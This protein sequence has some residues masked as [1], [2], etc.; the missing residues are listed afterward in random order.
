MAFPPL[1]DMSP[2]GEDRYTGDGSPPPAD[3]R[4]GAAGAPGLSS[5]DPDLLASELSE[6]FRDRIR[7][8]AA[9]RLRDRDAAEDVAQEV[10]RRTLEALRAG[11]V[12]NRDALPAFLFQTARHVCMQWGRSAGRR[13][14]AFSRIQ[15]EAS[16]TDPGEDTLTGLITQERREKVREAFTHLAAG[17]REVLNLSYVEALGADEIAR[18]LSSTPGAVRVRRHRA[19]HRLAEILGVTDRPDREL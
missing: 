16:E 18:R 8:F 4:G 7:F 19:L 10:L 17:D 14:R 11:R 12:E 9:R 13:D 15:S 1:T 2:P 3:N 6:R 5:A